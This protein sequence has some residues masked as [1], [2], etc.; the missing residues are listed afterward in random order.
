MLRNAVGGS[1]FPEKVL[2]RCIILYYRCEGVG[3]WRSNS[4]EKALRNR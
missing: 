1:A 3:G 2:G 4:Q